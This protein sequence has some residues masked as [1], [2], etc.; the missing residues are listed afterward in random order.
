MKNS[1]FIK[2]I[3]SFDFK[4]ITKLNVDTNNIK[5][6]SGV[7]KEKVKKSYPNL[8]EI[9]SIIHFHSKVQTTKNSDFLST[10]SEEELDKI[11]NTI[12]L[13]K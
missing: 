1:N 4:T 6:Y 3:V 7:D 5:S 12:N 11:L 2:I 13:S 9:N 8:K 10:V